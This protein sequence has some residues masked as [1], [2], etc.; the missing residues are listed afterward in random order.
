MRLFMHRHS[1]RLIAF[2]LLTIVNVAAASADFANYRS[3]FI[4]RFDY[5]YNSANIPQMVSAINA[6]MQSAQDEGFTEV[7]WQVR[8]RAD[9]LYNS[10][11]EPPATGLTPGFDPLQTAINA[12]HARGL[13]LHAWINATPMWNSATVN[14]PA[15]HIFNNTNPSFRLMDINGNL[16][17]QA[18][19][20]NYSSANPVLPEVHTHIN[21]VARDIMTNYAVD[22]IHLDYIRYLP[23]ANNAAADFNQMP[24]DPIAHSMFKAATDPDGPGG[25]QQGLDAGN[26]A[27]FSAYKSYITGRITDLVRSIKNTVDAAEVTTGRTMEL[28]ASVWRDPDV[29]KN[30]Y[31]Q[32]YRTWIQQE[33]LDVA[34]PMIYLSAS[35]DDT[36]F[37]ANLMNS[38]NAR[39]SSGSSTR[40]APNLGSYLHV[41]SGGGGVALT[42]SQ[43]Q[44]AYNFTADGVGFYDYPAFFSGY[45]ASER[46]QIENF[47]NSLE[48]PSPGSGNVLDDFENDEGHFVWNYNQSPSTQSF[49]LSS[50]TT[51][52]RVTT[53]HQGSGVASQLLNYVIDGAAPDTWQNRHNSG[54][55]APA[56]PANNVALEATGWVGFWLKTDDAGVSVRISIDDPIGNT[57]LE[58]GNSLSV[59]ADNEWHLYQWDLDDADQWTGFAGG[60]NGMI[61]GVNG[62]VSIDSIWFNGTGSVQIFLDTVS[63]NPFGPITAVPEPA[64]IL[65]AIAASVAVFNFRRR[66][67][68]TADSATLWMQHRSP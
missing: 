32:D 45:T 35:N 20:S 38:I 51:I 67:G 54:I 21:N 7:I 13:K 2:A 4:D 8:G 53:E 63:H 56:N 5:V 29:G 68:V 17:P 16:E 31:M 58:M 14:P 37:N 36:F 65:L 43:L 57:A 66:S 39:D 42:L 40:I 34:M 27:N 41:N 61:D 62:F 11:Y 28:T 10:N 22:G 12:A 25:P 23:G 6:Q 3:I 1:Q 48:P 19:W 59:I 44:R 47:F 26:I 46:L 18:G 30:D 52:E 64:A 60:A 50:A 33:L 15:G 49:G 55:G 9:A 24:H